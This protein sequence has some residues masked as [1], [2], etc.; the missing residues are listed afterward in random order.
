LQD[1]IKL[2]LQKEASLTEQERLLLPWYK[3]WLFW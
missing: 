2:F 3:K 1:R